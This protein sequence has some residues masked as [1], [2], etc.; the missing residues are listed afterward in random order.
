MSAMKHTPGPRDV[1]IDD[2]AFR[3]WFTAAGPHRVETIAQLGYCKG[4]KRIPFDCPAAR[5]AV[6]KAS[7]QIGGAS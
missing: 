7:S 6:A 4:W 1:A 5:A 3:V 2:K